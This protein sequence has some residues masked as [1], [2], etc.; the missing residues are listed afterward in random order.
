MKT[1]YRILAL[2]VAFVLLF[3]PHGSA[4]SIPD[5]KKLAEKFME[6]IHSRRIILK[7]PVANHMVTTIGTNILAALPPQPFNYAFYIINDDRFNA[8]ASP[9]ANIFFNRG[10]ICS[11]S[12]IDELAGIMGHEIAHSV[13]RH[14]SQSIDRAKLVNI[15]TLA[16]MLAGAIVGST[17]GGSEAAR[18]LSVGSM[19]AGQSTMLSFTRDNETEA[20]QKALLFL[21]RPVT[22]PKAC[23]AV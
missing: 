3:P 20:D 14:V 4:I 11:L 5:E 15:G 8:F 23:W 18:A 17:G 7:D 1:R 22:H 21:K 16:G 13:S 12:S 9:A 2:A 19:A 10:L 6:K